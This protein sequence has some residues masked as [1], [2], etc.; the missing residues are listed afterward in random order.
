MHNKNII[1]NQDTLVSGMLLRIPDTIDMQSEE[2]ISLVTKSFIDAY[3]NY[4]KIGKRD[5]AVWLIY[6]CYAHVNKNILDDYQNRID[7]DDI[8]VVRNYIKRFAK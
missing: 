4:K 1:K 2:N 6:S 5:S 7:A 3:K 8:K